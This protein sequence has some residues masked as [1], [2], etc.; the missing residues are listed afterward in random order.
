MSALLRLYFDGPFDWNR[1]TFE[2]FALEWPGLLIV[3]LL[4]LT[5]GLL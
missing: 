2:K 3:F 5:E 4:V 1:F